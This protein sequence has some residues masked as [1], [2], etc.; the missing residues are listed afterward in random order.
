MMKEINTNKRTYQLTPTFLDLYPGL[1]ATSRQLMKIYHTE[2]VNARWMGIYLNITR[3]NYLLAGKFLTMTHGKVFKTV[4]DYKTVL[5]F[6]I[7]SQYSMIPKV[8]A[9][10]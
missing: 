3:R 10:H 6:M 1:N 2:P 8:W 9:L 7:E 5:K 4:D